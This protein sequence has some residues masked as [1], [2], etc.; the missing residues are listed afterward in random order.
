MSNL[1]PELRRWIQAVSED[2]Q[3]TVIM[4]CQP[5]FEGGVVDGIP[6]GSGCKLNSVS[7]GVVVANVNVSSLRYLGQNE[8]IQTIAPATPLNLL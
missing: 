6:K 4:R 5:G 1:V 2:E 7:P 3:I 8:Q